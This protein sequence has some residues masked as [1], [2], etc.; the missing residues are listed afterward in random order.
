MTIKLRQ[1]GIGI[2]IAIGGFLL[3]YGGILLNLRFWPWIASG[4]TVIFAVSTLI[5]FIIVW[6]VLRRDR[7]ESRNVLYD[8]SSL[9]PFGTIAAIFGVM[10][11]V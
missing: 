2:S 5:H 1:L 3:S 6:R 9:S 10:C 7:R 11:A 4:L 8:M